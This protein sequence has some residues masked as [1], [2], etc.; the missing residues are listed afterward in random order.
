MVV[1]VTLLSLLQLNLWQQDTGVLAHRT[2]LQEKL[3]QEKENTKRL[4]LRN[5]Q[6]QA[7]IQD[8]NEGTEVIEEL[9]RSELKMLKPNEVLIQFK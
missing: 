9:A 6:L 7:E 2:T 3:K 1:L 4:S 5:S 8:L